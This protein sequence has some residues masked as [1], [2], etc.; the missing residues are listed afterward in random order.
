LLLSSVVKASVPSG[1]EAFFYFCH[2]FL[3]MTV[4]NINVNNSNKHLNLEVV[5]VTESTENRSPYHDMSLSELLAMVELISEEA[6]EL[7]EKPVYLH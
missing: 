3:A 7:V 1:A 4:D 5:P 2:N 6:Q